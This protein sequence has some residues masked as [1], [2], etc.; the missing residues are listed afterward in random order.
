MSFVAI[1]LGRAVGLNLTQR[2]KQLNYGIHPPPSSLSC[3]N[4]LCP[5]R[6]CRRQHACDKDPNEAAGGRE[7]EGGK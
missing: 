4:G 6:S 5:R 1:R 7:R 2:P 3:A